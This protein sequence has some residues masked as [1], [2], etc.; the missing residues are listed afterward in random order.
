MSAPEPI[1]MTLTAAQLLIAGNV[2]LMR[3]A[4]NVVRGAKGR[5]GASDGNG[6]WEIHILGAQAE[7]ATALYLNLSW[8]GSIGDYKAIDVGNRVNV[9]SVCSPNR[10]LLLHRADQDDV[11][12]V[13]VFAAPP[14]FSLIGWTLARDGKQDQFWQDPT[15]QDRPA[16]FV[17]HEA[18]QAMPALQAWLR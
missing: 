16:F 18:L 4:Q 6:S 15:H 8:D 1:T 10:R 11:P 2:G 5:Y 14:R 12:F 9:R 7:F 13:C 17:P 3:A